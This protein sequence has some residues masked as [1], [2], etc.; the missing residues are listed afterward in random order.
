MPVALFASSEGKGGEGLEKKEEISG[1][2]RGHWEKKFWWAYFSSKYKILLIWGTKKLYWGGVLEG[3]Y[4]LFKF[5]LCCYNTL[6]IKNILIK[7]IN[8]SLS[9]TIRFQKT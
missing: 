8:L 1:R 9:K 5:K 7:N 2:N 3:L 4:E 6:K